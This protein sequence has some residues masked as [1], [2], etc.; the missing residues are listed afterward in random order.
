MKLGKEFSKRKEK[1]INT[2]KINSVC[3]VVNSKITISFSLY[4]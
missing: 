4:Y 2:I 1:K 3:E